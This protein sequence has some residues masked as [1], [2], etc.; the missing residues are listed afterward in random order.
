MEKPV[1][2]F[3]EEALQ[4]SNDPKEVAYW[5]TNEVVRRWRERGVDCRKSKFKPKNLAKLVNMVK[6]GA[7]TPRMAKSVLWDVVLT[8]ED[9]EEYIERKGISIIRDPN[10]FKQVIL[11]VLEE[12]PN[13]RE[14]ASKNERIIDFICGEVQKKLDGR[15]DP[16]ILRNEVKKLVEEED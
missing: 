15:A 9:V 6:E 16:I 11:K 2:D 1:A 4:F 3:F 14:N 12:K 13:L 7:L 10:M 5:L 8:G